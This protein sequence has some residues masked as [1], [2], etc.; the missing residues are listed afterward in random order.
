MP[1]SGADPG[2]G[3]AGA[4]VTPALLRGW[5]LPPPGEDKG[6]RGSI[7][8]PA[9][10]PTPRAPHCSPASPPCAPARAS[11][12][13]P[14]PRRW[15]TPSRWP[16]PRRWCCPL[17]H[18]ASGSV[19]A[20]A[21]DDLADLLEKADVVCAGPGLDDADEATGLVAAIA[22]AL[23]DRPGWCST[24]TPSARSRPGP[25]VARALAGRLVAHPQHVRGRHPARARGTGRRRIPDAAREIAA[26]YGCVVAL[27]SAV[28]TPDGRSWIGGSG[29]AG[30]GTS[31]SGDV[32]AG[33][34]P[35]SWPGAPTPRRP[36]SGVP[37]CTRRPGNAS[38]RAS[39]RS[40]TWRA[41][42]S[43]RPRGCSRSC[44]SRTSEAR[45]GRL[46]RS[47]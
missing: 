2:D 40:A 46:G 32:L 15:R 28:A 42:S 47:S 8:S 35:G 38:R 17:R 30:L 3:H 27:R 7:S 36:P 37:T 39:A 18:T 1:R 31:G 6:D 25:E 41:N 45:G 22:G 33:S 5:P 10:P 23:P 43:T 19:R 24:R 16:F 29:Q 11:C 20:G 13:W 21:V 9:A 44:R 26:R 34:S 14:S 12:S 4:C